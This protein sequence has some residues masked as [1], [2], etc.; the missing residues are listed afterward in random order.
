VPGYVNHDLPIT[1]SGWDPD[2]NP[3]SYYVSSLPAAG[4]LYQYSGGVRGS[5]IN[6]ANTLVSDAGGKV[7]FAPGLNG[8]GNPYAAFN[9]T[10]NNGFS[11][12]TPAQVTAN[13]NLPL[14]P[15]LTNY[16][17]MTGT[18]GSSSFVLNFGGSSNATYSVWSSTNLTQWQLMGTSAEPS[19]GQYEF[20]DMT[21][22]NWPERFYRI[23]AP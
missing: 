1:L 16:F 4:T 8:A 5:L 2:G 6:V 20:F 11:G 18:N 19:P 23:S 3:L 22:T 7:I 14:A 15:Q 12:S 13:I 10:A 21:A 17:W 9:F